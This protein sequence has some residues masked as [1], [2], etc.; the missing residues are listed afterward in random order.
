MSDP[1]L[2]PKD[3]DTIAA[4]AFKAHLGDDWETA[5]QEAKAAWRDKVSDAVGGRHSQDGLP[6]IEAAIVKA[7]EAHFAAPVPTTAKLKAPEVPAEVKP[8]PKK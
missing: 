7:W 5:S 4:A 8:K 3:V 2:Y 1:I 6:G